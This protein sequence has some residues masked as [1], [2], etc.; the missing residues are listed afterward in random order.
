MFEGQDLLSLVRNLFGGSD[1]GTLAVFLAVTLAIWVLVA[2]VFLGHS[3]DI[4]KAIG[5]L[6]DLSGPDRGAPDRPGTTRFLVAVLAKF[7]AILV[8]DK[9]SQQAKLQARLTRA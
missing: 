7:G 8:P 6:R 3:R 2:A 9:E 1:P 4:Q 5:R